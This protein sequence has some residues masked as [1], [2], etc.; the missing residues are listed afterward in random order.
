MCLRGCCPRGPPPNPF[1]H[2]AKGLS[3]PVLATAEREWRRKRE[4]LFYWAPLV[5]CERSL[6]F[7]L[8]CD[9]YCWGASRLGRA[10]SWGDC[11]RADGQLGQ[12]GERE[13]REWGYERER[14]TW[15]GNRNERVG[16]RRRGQER[17]QRS[18]LII[19]NFV[20]SVAGCHRWH[21]PT[22]CF[23][24]VQTFGLWE[25]AGRI[26]C[27][28]YFCGCCLV[29]IKKVGAGKA[30]YLSKSKHVSGWIWKWIHVN[31]H[32][33]GLQNTEMQDSLR[34]LE[35]HGREVQFHVTGPINQKHM[36]KMH[37]CNIMLKWCFLI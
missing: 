8:T 13:G 11:G 35:L 7:L 31:Y 2:L 26:S 21:G 29:T 25:S 9:L 18:L 23:T 6:F 24:H 36:E 34:R 22:H 30:D 27:M 19:H 37:G 28:L 15:E 12:F 1:S 32:W 3:F 20:L 5:H 10:D 16:K 17:W 4:R 14:G 33:I